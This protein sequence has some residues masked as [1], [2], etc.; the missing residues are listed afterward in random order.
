VVVTVSN[1]L[2]TPR[3][4]TMQSKLKARRMQPTVV[5]AGE[6]G[7]TAAD[8]ELRVEMVKQYVPTVRG[9][10]EMIGGANAAEL[11]RNLAEKLRA[12]STI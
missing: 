5:T 10:C 2:G 12:Q 7:L 8:L 4:P 3:Y 1:E 11:A 6:L 9:E